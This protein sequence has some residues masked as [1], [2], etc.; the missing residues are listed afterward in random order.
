MNRLAENR[1]QAVE[2]RHERVTSPG[3]G[4][5]N[6]MTDADRGFGRSVE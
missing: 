5:E 2:Q 6:T 4:I 3:Q 1:Q